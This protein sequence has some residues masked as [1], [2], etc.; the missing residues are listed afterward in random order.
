RPQ[1]RLQRR[2]YSDEVLLAD[3]QQGPVWRQRVLHELS[4]LGSRESPADNDQLLVHAAPAPIRLACPSGS[5]V[6]RPLCQPSSA[7]GSSVAPEISCQRPSVSESSKAA[8]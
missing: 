7:C 3:Q 4:G 6:M 5:R 2:T 1:E 8:G